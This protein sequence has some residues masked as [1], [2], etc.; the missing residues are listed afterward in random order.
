MASN[1]ALTSS[2]VTGTAS[3]LANAGE[4][5]VARVNPKITGTSCRNR[6]RLLDVMS[7][8]SWV[9][10][11]FAFGLEREN[12]EALGTDDAT[13]TAKKKDTVLMADKRLGAVVLVMMVMRWIQR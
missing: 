8:F 13:A 5:E 2:R 1:V 12:P 11:I 10:E 3:S 9:A 7:A 4:A 6:R